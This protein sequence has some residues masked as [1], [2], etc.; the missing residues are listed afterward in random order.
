MV[1]T[2]KKPA[3]KLPPRKPETK[4]T[5]TP[6]R[7]K[8]APAGPIRGS[9]LDRLLAIS[10]GH[11]NGF[12]QGSSSSDSDELTAALPKRVGRTNNNRWKIGSFS[13][14]DSSDES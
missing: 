13:S 14:E 4:N 7:P 1:A 10:R 8:P 5:G 2:T 11:A 12:L 6:I 3:V 9:L